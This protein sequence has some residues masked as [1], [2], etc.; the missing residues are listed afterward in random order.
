[1]NL[2]LSGKTALVTGASSAGI[3]RAIALRLA[4]EGASVAIA[5]R[6]VELL[7]QVAG[8]IAAA[9]CPAPAVLEADLYE[10]ESPQRLANAAQEALGRVDIL[11]NCA[12]GSR[13]VPLDATSERWG[14]A[15]M[16][17]FFRVRELTHALLPAMVEQRWG[18]IVNITGSS[19]PYNFN[20]AASA[21][22]AIHAWSKCLSREVGKFGVTSNC[23]QPGRIMSEQ[24]RRIYPT[25]ER[26]RQATLDI[27]VG[28]LG[29]P[30]ELADLAVFLSSPCAAYI[31]G[32]VIPVDGG[33]KRFA[34]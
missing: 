1:M 7:N 16:L 31:T 12:G 10:P 24:I 23:I 9:G 3:G 13:P 14:E 29:Q 18:R 34:F 21:K 15:M 27:P 6:R 19:E 30:D 20:A 11:V 33:M 2:E 4:S 8:E 32:T 26:Q 28:R 25:E 5:A 22:A 17:N